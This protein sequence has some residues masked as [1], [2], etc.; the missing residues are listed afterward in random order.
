MILPEK[1]ARLQKVQNRKVIKKL[2]VTKRSF[3]VALA[4]AQVELNQI[5]KQTGASWA[6]VFRILRALKTSQPK[7]KKAG[8]RLKITPEMDKFIVDSVQSNRKLL[9]KA[10]QKLL[11]EKYGVFLS[12]PR[13]RFRLQMAGLFG[14]VCSQKPLLSTLNKLKRFLWALQHRKWTVQQWKNILWYDEKN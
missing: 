14:H 4:E 8:R 10:V 6:T 5:V 3:I 13:I 9:P 11:E 12:L 2:S 7:T 1:S